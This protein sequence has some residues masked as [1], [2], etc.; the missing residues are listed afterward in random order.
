VRKLKKLT[1]IEML[2]GR[3][4]GLATRT[5]V[6]LDQGVTVRKIAENL[7]AHY[8]APVTDGHVRSFRLKRWGP[9]KNQAEADFIALEALFKKC[10]G[11]YGLDLA[12]F[13]RV[14][15]LLGTSDIKVAD[16]VRLTIVKMRAQDLKEEE[17]KFKTGQLKFDKSSGDGEGETEDNEAKTKRVMNKIRGIFGLDPLPENEGRQESGAGKQES[18]ARSQES[19][20]KKQESGVRSQES[21]AA[22]PASEAVG[23]FPETA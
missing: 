3:F 11:N 21:E 19:G 12:A 2:D 16:S 15:E 8:P 7:R 14:R 6:M 23:A 1:E 4:P 13:A 9:A 10:G 17:F 20:A 22:G 18:G 5:R